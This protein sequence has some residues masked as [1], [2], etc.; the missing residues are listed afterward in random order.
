M[1]S[2][3]V[4]RFQSKFIEVISFEFD[5][6]FAELSNQFIDSKTKQQSTTVEKTEHLLSFNRIHGKRNVNTML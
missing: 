2:K 3:F 5:F 6:R 1:C 4:G